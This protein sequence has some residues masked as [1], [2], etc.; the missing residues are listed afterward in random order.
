MN[1]FFRSLGYYPIHVNNDLCLNR[2]RIPTTLLRVWNPHA[3]LAAMLPRSGISV[4]ILFVDEMPAR[5]PSDVR[6]LNEMRLFGVRGVRRL[7]ADHTVP[8]T[9]PLQGVQDHY[10]LFKKIL[11]PGHIISG[12]PGW[13]LPRNFRKLQRGPKI[14]VRAHNYAAVWQHYY[15]LSTL[16]MSLFLF[17]HQKQYIR[18]FKALYNVF[19]VTEAWCWL[20]G[21]KVKHWVLYSNERWASRTSKYYYSVFSISYITSS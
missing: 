1:V 5:C 11:R 9:W 19:P 15:S 17:W 4:R 10:K 16:F 21:A 12:F 3:P 7:F 13:F 6:N 18:H 8:G 14:P 20:L 2:V